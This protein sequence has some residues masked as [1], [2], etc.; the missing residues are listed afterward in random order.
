MA[1]LEGRRTNRFQSEASEV[2]SQL[3]RSFSCVLATLGIRRPVELQ[4]LLN[5]H[6]KLSWQICKVASDTGGM[7]TAP[8]IPPRVH[9]SRFVEG[10]EACGVPAEQ[11][12]ALWAA[13]DRFEQLVARHAGDRTSFNSLIASEPT[14]E[15]LA[16]DL[17]HRRNMFRGEC[18]AMGVH[19]QTRLTTVI[20]EPTGRGTE[21]RFLAVNGYVGLR[22]LRPIET[23]RIHRFRLR[24]ARPGEPFEARDH[25]PLTI[26]SPDS[27]LLESFST[28]PLPPTQIN[29][30]QAGEFQWIETALDRPEV[31]NLGRS[32]ML[33]G[34]RSLLESPLDQINAMLS[35]PVEVVLVDLLVAPNLPVGAP[36]MSYFRG[37]DRVADRMPDLLPLLGDQ[38]IVSLGHGTG[39]LATPD[40]ISYPELIRGAAADLEQDIE[41]FKVW[42]VRV[43]YPLYHSTVR[44]SLLGAGTEPTEQAR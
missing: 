30:G 37:D 29:R 41:T 2:L 11:V 22:V 5:L 15:W 33:F 34:E 28:R 20:L 21:C 43:E 7:L 9:V 24:P 26:G 4:K 36:Q 18:H 38:T 19:A 17:Q 39:N 31:G 25:R 44:L 42:R 12:R 13:Y 1:V 14:D 6:A 35:L 32:T 23:V 8:S 16:A 10:A 40:V 3:Q 27:F